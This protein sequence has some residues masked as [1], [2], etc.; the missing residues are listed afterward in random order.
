LA[1]EWSVMRSETCR[2]DVDGTA[3]TAGLG[4]FF[5]SRLNP[6]KTQN[7]CDSHRSSLE[8]LPP[9]PCQLPHRDRLLLDRPQLSANFASDLRLPLSFGPLL[10]RQPPVL[11]L[12]R[13]D[14]RKAPLG[15]SSGRPPSVTR[16]APRPLHSRTLARR[17]SLGSC[18]TALARP[19]R[20]EPRR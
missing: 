2:S 8:K 19:L 9:I 6:K 13:C 20:A 4:S 18:A 17:S 1:C 3:V 11:E 7:R 12:R 14:P 15:P 16:A 5:I 10:F